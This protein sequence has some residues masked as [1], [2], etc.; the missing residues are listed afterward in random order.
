[1][2]FISGG[3]TLIKKAWILVWLLLLADI[4]S[5]LAQETG[6]TGKGPQ[7]PG[8]DQLINKLDDMQKKIDQLEAESKA[9]KKLQITD[10]EKQEKEKEVLTAAGKEYSLQNKG[11]LELEYSLAFDYSSRDQVKEALSIE[12]MYDYTLTHTISSS[13]GILDNLTF[14]NSLP[15]V[16]RYNKVDTNDELDETDIGDI[17]VTFQFEPV[18]KPAGGYSVILIAGASL[19]T[20]RSPYK[21]DPK[22][23]LSTGNGTYAYSAGVNVSQPIDPLVVFGGANYSYTPKVTGLNTP[24]GDK[25]LQSV[26]PGDKISIGLGF[27]YAL[28]YI[29]SFSQQVTMSYAKGSEYDFKQGVSSVKNASYMS[30][31]YIIGVG[32]RLSTKTTLFTNLVLGLTG[33]SDFSFSLRVPFS[34]VL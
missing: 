10:V 15:F 23:E 34:F 1:M 16:Y 26:T 2:I 31:S 7:S 8:Q 32:W 21:I 3:R 22:N 12:R 9:R 29:V 18:K 33:G 5:A 25:I 11:T 17:S 24:F 6:T 13:Y 20:G 28:S 14:N 27:G 19:P 30:A 4:S